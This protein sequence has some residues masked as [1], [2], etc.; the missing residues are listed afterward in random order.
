MKQI[1][2]KKIDIENKQKTILFIQ[3]KV[4]KYISELAV[5]SKSYETVI[6]NL[7]GIEK[8]G[9]T[10]SD[11]RRIKYFSDEFKNLASTFGYR[12][13][14]VDDIK[15]EHATMLPYLDNIELRANVAYEKEERTDIKSDSSASDFVRLIWSYLI[16]LQKTSYE[17][18]GNHPNFI[19]F[20]EP[21]QHSMSEN[22]VNKLLTT[23]CTIPGLQSIV[24]ASFDESDDNFVAS[25]KGLNKDNYNLIRLPKKIISK[26]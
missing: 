13:A 10:G 7:S 11:W 12:S 19:L 23:I 17:L 5:L 18:N 4:D 24:A 20:D 3:E 26:L 1:Y 6:I 14:K 21:A 2:E 8:T 15:I 16:S 22:S 9:L 25:T